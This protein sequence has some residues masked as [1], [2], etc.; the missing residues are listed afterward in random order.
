MQ[1]ASLQKLENARS[2]A[3]QLAEFIQHPQSNQKPRAQQHTPAT[4][5]TLEKSEAAAHAAFA[6]NDSDTAIDTSQPT[7]KVSTS[8]SNKVILGAQF[9]SAKRRNETRISAFELAL[10]RNRLWLNPFLALSLLLWLP[11]VLE[12]FT[13]QLWINLSALAAIGLF[14]YQFTRTICRVLHTVKAP[15]WQKFWPLYMLRRGIIV[16]SVLLL[17]G[18]LAPSNLPFFSI[19]LGFVALYWLYQVAQVLQ[20]RQA[21]N[22]QLRHHNYQ[23]EAKA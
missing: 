4:I 17:F 19:Y 3:E 2:L 13:E 7:Q 1:A 20:R 10:W 23:S 12:L 16:G 14:E 6:D 18:A 15:L 21:Q 5:D 22:R 9:D 8:T 11:F